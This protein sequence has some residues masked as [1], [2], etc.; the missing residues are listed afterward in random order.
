MFN[1]KYIGVQEMQDPYT[2]RVMSS[3][4][5]MQTMKYIGFQ[6]HH[7][8]NYIPTSQCSVI[9]ISSKITLHDDFDQSTQFLVNLQTLM[10]A[11]LLS[12]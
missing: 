12:S 10:Y 1:N 9:R 4:I 11:S 6:S 7:G 8:E 2:E 5:A 3:D